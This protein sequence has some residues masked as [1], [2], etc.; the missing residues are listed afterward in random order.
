MWKLFRGAALNSAL[1]LAVVLALLGPGA[2]VP[3]AGAQTLPTIRTELDYYE[4]GSTVNFTGAGFQPGETVNVL[5]IGATNGSRVTSQPSADIVSGNIAGNLELPIMF[6]K[7]YS[8]T[9]TGASSGL[10]AT[11]SFL[12]P[13]KLDLIA[14]VGGSPVTGVIDLHPGDTATFTA[15][16]STNVRGSD[17][18]VPGAP[19]TFSASGGTLT[20]QTPANGVTG[21][22]GKVTVTYT[23]G[24]VTGQFNPGVTADCGDGCSPASKSQNVRIRAVTSLTTNNA[25]G[26]VGG[27]V[28][29][30]A[31][32]SSASTSC[33]NAKSI[34]FTLRGTSVGS[35][36]TNASG[37]A[38]L[39]N[40]NL[41]A[42]PAGTYLDTATPPGI[43]A[44]FGPDNNCDSSSD[45][46]TLT[47]NPAT[48][49]DTT[50]PTVLS[51]NRAGTNPTNAASVDFTVTFSES[52]TGVDAGDFVLAISGV[53]GASITPPVTGSGTTWTVSVNTGSGNGTIG[54]NLNDDD[55]IADG[56]GNKLGG[57]GTGTA[58]SP[59]GPGNGSFTGQVYT[60]EKTVADTTAPT[61]AS[62][63]INDNASW[64]NSSTGGVTVDISAA[65]NVGIVKYRLAES[66][67][68]LDTAA[69]V[70]VTPTTSFSASDVAFTL[71]GV[72]AASKTVYLRVFDAAGLS[73]D[74]NDTIGW[75][76]TK[77][78][79]TATAKD[80]LDN[81][82][83]AGTWTNKD[84]TVSFSCTDALSLV[85][86]NTVLGATKNAEGENQSVTNTGT[87]TDNAGNVA[88]AA[89]FSDIDI[90]KTKPT[91]SASAK[92]SSNRAYTAGTW[93]NKSIT[94]SFECADA[95]SGVGTDTVQGDTKSSEG[96]N[97]SVT[98]TG[99]CSDKAGNIADA[100][101][102]SNIDIDKTNPA[103]V[104]KTSLDNCSSPGTNGWCKGT[105][106][107][108]FTAS[109]ALS[110]VDNPPCSSS[111]AASCDLTKST[112]TNGSAVKIA[113]GQVCD[114]AGNCISGIE[115]AAFKIDSVAPTLNPSVSPNPVVLN[116]T[117][118]GAA[119]AS[120]ATSGIATQG[121]GA[122]DTSS[123]GSGKTVSCTAVDNAGNSATPQNATYSVIYA[124]GGS[125]LGSPGHA[126]LQPVNASSP[127]SVFK[128][129]STVPAKFRVC[130]A[131]GASVGNAG[132]V[133]SFKKTG[134]TNLPPGTTINE[135]VDSTTP[136]TE[137]RWDPTSKQ[138][139]FNMNTKDLR[140]NSDLDYE[141]ELND[142][143]KIPFGFGLK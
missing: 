61:N 130:D 142:G 76:K 42:T 5:A 138:W 22:D 12:D 54:L 26:T 134:E 29:L 17:V 23:A 79:I 53:S 49:T 128:Q 84:I 92:D 70:A 125:C 123:V 66:A 109:D 107:A 97:Q 21:T 62:I 139:I 52:V 104:T 41:G 20:G 113:S 81:T 37:V 119:G 96:E 100:A 102:F 140:A 28:N 36:N 137:F 105:Q 75:D 9:A 60:I 27:T 8:L 116:G 45:A 30:T 94:V 127:L 47:V 86:T 19:I 58:A 132:V 93:T 71:T 78:V 77:P 124:V 67:S 43:L 7:Q 6:E 108:G 65:D 82:Y 103:V 55:S 121:C 88:D 48:P 143:S 80:S 106:T 34:A 4:P 59:G 110:G 89:T 2:A 126:I 101:T 56:A 15:F 73:A 35:A 87:C 46:A 90:D 91:I 69:D 72:E 118:T 44:S 85:A 95:L 111:G 64:T 120:D 16:V 33:V 31:T 115:S 112:T 51:I 40:V 39:S 114:V 11:S 117:A 99:G 136:N 24:S 13:S 98:N 10:Q 129:G 68:G 63:T 135:T 83:T 122:V 50:P 74:A 1:A 133:K 14:I 131:N 18:G 57:T 3:N 25:T 38:T 32:L 141:I